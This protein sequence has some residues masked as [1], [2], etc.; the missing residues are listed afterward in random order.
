M[1]TTK[2]SSKGQVIIPKQVRD[3]YHWKSGLKIQ[4]VEVEDGILLKPNVH[5]P[6]SSLEEVAGCL[7]YQSAEKSEEAIQRAMKHGARN[8]WRDG[9]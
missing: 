3:S 4:V 1:K 6:R 9:D 5:F 8:A 2:L 7:G